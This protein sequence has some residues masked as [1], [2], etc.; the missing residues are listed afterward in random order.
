MSATRSQPHDVVVLRPS[1]LKAIGMAVCSA[2]IAVLCFRYW[3]DGLEY[4][5]V[6]GSFLALGAVFYTMHLVPGAYALTLSREGLEVMELYAVKRFAWPEVSEFMVRRGILGATV[7]FYHH[8]SGTELPSHEKLNE[9][10][11]YA[12][13]KMAEVLNEWRVR[14]APPGANLDTNIWSSR[15]E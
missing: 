12:P 9:S 4:G 2:V 1:P 15:N 13:Y 11:G 7:Q 6:A 14:A 8:P 5:W 10:F 3:V